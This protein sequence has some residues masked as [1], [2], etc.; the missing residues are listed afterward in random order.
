MSFQNITNF[1][2]SFLLKLKFNK[3]YT[4]VWQSMMIAVDDILQTASITFYI[5]V[6]KWS[7]T[8]CLYCNGPNS[9][10]WTQWIS[11]YIIDAS[12]GKWVI[13]YVY[14]GWWI[15]II[16]TIVI[17]VITILTDNDA[18]ASYVLLENITLYW[19]LLTAFKNR[20][21]VT[22]QY[23]IQL[24]VVY[25]QLGSLIFPYF[26]WTTQTDPKIGITNSFLINWTTIFIA[27]WTFLLVL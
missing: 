8:N 17:L 9:S 10:D 5:T 26:D 19:I 24:S 2:P 12:S 11:G 18:N 21:W 27:I 22:K 14:F 25:T 13:E 6:L 1:N 7:Q 15:I 3:S 20:V 4:G 16:F 23:S